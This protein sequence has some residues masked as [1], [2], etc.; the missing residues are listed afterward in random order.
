MKMKFKKPL[1]IALAIL[2]VGVIILGSF[3]LFTDRATSN[4]LKLSTAKFSK[5]GYTI[6]RE[7]EDVHY[8]AGDDITVKVIE[9]NSKTEAVQSVVKMSVAWVSP[10]TSNSPFGNAKTADNATIQVD[11][12][13]VDYTVNKDGTITFEL[14][15]HAMKA[16]S[17]NNS[18]NIT[19]HIPDSL[20]STGNLNFT[21]DG[22]KLS[23]T[24]AMGGTGFSAEFS[25]DDLNASSALDFSAKVIW[26]FSAA[27]DKSVIGSLTGSNGNYG[28]KVEGSG[29]M[30]NWASGTASKQSNYKD[31]VT[32]V[33]IGD[34]ISN[35]GNYAFDGFSKI[36]SIVIPKDVTK[37]GN[38][39]FGH[40]E[41][42]TD[43][44]FKESSSASITFPAAG[45]STGAFYVPSYLK[46]TFNFNGNADAKA[47]NWVTDNR[48]KDGITSATLAYDD[49]KVGETVNAQ[50]SIT[51]A[52]SDKYQSIKYEVISGSEFAK[53]DANTGVVTGVK[54]GTATVKVT[55]VDA[56]GD[57]VTAQ[58]TVNVT[59]DTPILAAQ[60][61]W[62][63]DAL[64]TNIL[65]SVTI[66]DSYTPDE[67]ESASWDA[68]DASV[69]GT[70]TAY[71]SKDKT[72]LT[73]AGNG[74][75]LIF[76]NPDSSNAF[77]DLDNVVSITNMDLLDTRNVT[78]MSGMF[79]GNAALSA[80]DVGSFNV[81]N[82]TDMSDMFSDV[83]VLSLDL[84]KH[85]ATAKDGTAYTAWNPTKAET[86]SAMFMLHGLGSENRNLQSVDVTGWETNS[87]TDMYGMF[88]DCNNLTEI[89]GISEWNTS[90][91]TDMAALFMKCYA[92]K[93]IVSKWDTGSVETV[94]RMFQYCDTLKSIDISNWD[95]SNMT[96]TKEMFYGCN[97]FT[98]LTL[99]ATLS[100]FDE[101]FASSCYKLT[102]FTFLQP[103]DMDITFSAA[104]SSTGA[105]S[106]YS[107]YTEKVPLG[108]E[109]ISNNVNVL[110]YGWSKNGRGFTVTVDSVTGG[111][112]TSDVTTAINGKTVTLTPAASAG[113]TYNGATVSYTDKSGAAKTI[114]LASGELTFT[115]PVAN[116]TVTPK[117]NVSTGIAYT[118][119]HWQ[120]NV[121]GGTTQND[122]NFTLKET[123]NLAGTT[124]A[125]VSPAVK[126]YTGF[127]APSKQ[128][129]TV[130]GDGSTVV[131]Y[132]YTRNSYTVTLNKGTGI[133]S[134]TGAGTYKYGQSVT[135]DAT[136]SNGYAW[137]K[138][139]GTHTST[140]KK[141]TFTMPASNV[142]DTANATVITYTISYNLNGGTLGSGKTNPTSYNVTSAAF[143][144]N[145][146]TK[147]G[148][149]FAGWTGANGT[150]PQTT[151][152]VTKGSTGEKSYT[153]NWTANTNTP[154]KVQY[155]Q[156]NVDGGDEHN[157][158]NFTLVNTENL[159]GTTGAS[160]T[161]ET[162]YFYGGFTTPSK[163]TVIIAADG[164][165]V[166]NYYYT[167]NSYKLTLAKGTGIASVT[168]AG[169]YKYGQ[170]VTIDATV[171][172]GYKWKTWTGSNF[173]GTTSQKYTYTMPQ[174]DTT[175]T[176]NATVV[177]YTISYNLNG[178]TLG[179]GKT[180]PTSYNV[181]SAAFTLNNPTKT[182]YTFAG[183]TGANGTTPQTT[184]TV[185]KG[186]T[187]E[188]SYIANWTA[189]TDTA[190]TV[191]HW[192]QNVDGGTAQNDTNFTLKD[193]QNLA[194]TTGASVSPAVKS[195]TGFT[196]PSKQTV[197]VAADGSTVVNY[198]YTRNSYTVTVK[199][200]T[201]GTMTAA[202]T[203]ARYGETIT[204]TWTTNAGYSFNGANGVV[205]TDDSSVSNMFSLTWN[206]P[207]G[208]SVKE[209]LT[210]KMKA[211]D[212][213]LTP[214]WKA[215][216]GIAY[217]VKHWQQNV[218][219]GDAQNS[220]NFTLKETENLTGTTAAS[221]SPAV[222]SY[223]GFTAPS[224]QTVT[225]AG[226]GSTVVNYY[227]TRNSY[228][229]TVKDVT[230]GTMTAEPTKAR[231]GKTITLTPAANAGY[232]YDSATV[233]YKDETGANKSFVLVSD[234][235][236][237]GSSGS[238]TQT[239]EMPAAD[240]T[241]TPAWKA[242]TNTAYTVKHW[243]QN[244]DGGD[245]Q[246]DT[247]FTLKD[248][249]NL[250][251]TTGA[252]V[253]P[254]VKSYTG[255]T[256]PSKQTVTVA[257]DGSTVVNYYYTRNSY[258]V[259]L[260]KGTGIAS[261]TGAGTYKYGQS[262]TIDATASNGYAWSKWHWEEWDRDIS[263]QKYTFN[264]LG[265]DMTFTANAES[266]AT[267]QAIYCASDYSLTFIRDKQLY[268]AGNT[269]N[270]KKVTAV[271]T[272][273][274]EKAY[275]SYSRIPWA[276]YASSIKSV[277]FKDEIK[278]ISTAYWFMNFKKCSSFNV[279]NLNTSKVTNMSDMFR[280]AGQS[281][282]A[283]TQF[284]ITGTDDWDVSN[285]TNMS[286]LFYQIAY[287]STKVNIGD[288]SNWDVSNVTNMRQMFTWVGRMSTLFDIGDLSNWN[289]SNVTDFSGMFS[290]AGYITTNFNIGDLSNWDVSS[291]TTMA[292]M[293]SS[294]GYTTTNFNIGDL[295][296]WD[297]SSV[298]DFS[299]MFSSTG[300]KSSEVYIGDLSN[301]NTSNATNMYRMFN[302]FG[303]LCSTIDIGNIN[304]WD[305][306]KVT[307]M[308]YMM[309]G[310]YGSVPDVNLDLS[311]WDTSSVTNMEFMFD[312]FGVDSSSVYLDLSNWNTSNVTTMYYM[313]NDIAY[314]ASTFDL[315]GLS[316]W[317]VSSVT[318][319]Q[320][321]FFE[322]GY[323]A[324]S[325]VL[326]LSQWDVSS[327]E[328]MGNY[329]AGDSSTSY[330]SK[331]MFTYA[332]Y[333]AKTFSL[334]DLS[335]WDT[336]NVTDMGCM[337]DH[338]GYS[339]S[340]TLDL[341]SWN[342][343]N[344]TGYSHFNYMVTTKVK[345]P[346]FGAKAASLSLAP[347]PTFEL[348]ADVIE[349]TAQTI[350][351][352]PDFAK[353][354]EAAS[355]NA[356][357]GTTLYG[358]LVDSSL[359]KEIVLLEDF[360]E[361]LTSVYEQD[362]EW[363]MVIT[364]L[365][366]KVQEPAVVETK[367]TESTDPTEVTE[368][369]KA[370]EPTE[371]TETTEP[372]KET[373][374]TEPT[375][376][377]SQTGSAATE[378][379]QQTEATEGTSAASEPVETQATESAIDVTLSIAA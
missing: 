347:E 12:T 194:G 366:Q 123:E 96:N 105:F 211:G 259:T 57:T 312:A 342:V 87:V 133:A 147:T 2:L 376:V 65:T 369:T 25:H 38:M 127:T 364:P 223:T 371:S 350:S 104:G 29:T 164:S 352:I 155:W 209:E 244:V 205:A 82:V 33:T 374:P 346:T 6:S 149:T 140:T 302:M 191:K 360:E 190:Y 73:I 372:V 333:K 270:G 110:N 304:Y 335:N 37:L 154:Y 159:T 157:S 47:Y 218:D 246:N 253:S 285:V 214:Q 368:E 277:N 125:S 309:F 187:G 17:K 108:T 332:G 167:R 100:R 143:T 208:S 203:K 256:A 168:G 120:Q 336:S 101:G 216:S 4:T 60:K 185:T 201:G 189:N 287:N 354:N 7:Y 269:Y 200:V 355:A 151:V 174:F 377:D 361:T 268:K 54:K 80:L 299:S 152:T 106:A 379:T 348:P 144:L 235:S 320:S 72:S 98:E 36:T 94:Y 311:N 249:Q 115:M 341:R 62:R 103:A 92:L 286:G 53:V 102:K 202:P 51:P 219:G 308:S 210:F 349:G 77:A 81:S 130:A 245:E 22:V 313:F 330:Y 274:E 232:S 176:A 134:V 243:Q 183:W 117:W 79:Y 300:Y 48:M 138:W 322:A 67:T 301:W 198:Y 272:G 88:T 56:N 294:A 199:N 196:A 226:D 175:V 131:N 367:P 71:L 314:S 10:D 63:N 220:T 182:G 136:A 319:M 129:V 163:Q 331:G 43:I 1:T 281:L 68:S 227:Y 58:G 66:V 46:T 32:N 305:T 192:Q 26:D 31:S 97:S 265:Q 375:V 295:S 180:N 248:T 257:G 30:Y 50:L 91:V 179:S 59:L 112:L 279:T 21:F 359:A 215:K 45:S 255:F 239:F 11:G 283:S 328:T 76:A 212:V 19:F 173:S 135:I 64:D 278:P 292:G 132:Y 118:V 69:P 282:T 378:P 224:K 90:K 247:N 137:S 362:P 122:T 231:Y 83:G 217:T 188:K 161:P 169:T 252:S 353:L 16:S 142:T 42:L 288:L 258:T 5:D 351:A 89:K 44:T 323:S 119:K 139:S 373:D 177:N 93:S 34:G 178:G 222:K 150:T 113:Y 356:P 156:Q 317:D 197:I 74:Y 284:L 14:P 165:T 160:V 225:I 238:G 250:T 358:W 276:S 325:F 337:F 251:G 55:I 293:F 221:V 321:M 121:D 15:A 86:F 18:R 233:S 141:Y 339:A 195:Y 326:D 20:K 162:K 49:V 184:V 370:T 146:P 124:G 344:V 206:P 266:A 307:D 236:D 78:N 298:T 3:A 23:Q 296:N 109:V 273:F 148:Y 153:A 40:C 365:Y 254:A 343:K 28:V 260:N 204:L 228:T 13:S 39:S 181:T 128:T 35:I 193:T 207:T 297:V 289:V 345:A 99:P 171:S 111:K 264:M 329:A 316:E 85:Q 327:V 61:T 306:S 41:K 340:Y 263:T 318:D 9:G 290:S 237:F 315:I 172:N 107:L 334:G 324:R 114:D 241:V 357:E 363:E 116:V 158:T 338:A 267:P 303:R 261:V 52:D 229:V 262:V 242:N 275:T 27:Q 75:G 84:H 8:A 271:Y 310:F 186:S 240:V 95:M 213:T 166:V 280:A 291:A 170:S 126:S 70:V 230:G 145:N 234:E 24:T